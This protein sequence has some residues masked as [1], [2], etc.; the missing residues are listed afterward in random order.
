YDIE[1][2]Q[3]L[4]ERIPVSIAE[5]RRLHTAVLVRI[6]IQQAALEAELRDAPL[7]LG[8]RVV[9]RRAGDLRKARHADEL[10]RHQLAASVDQI[11]RDL[12]PVVHDGRG[13]LR[14]H[15]LKRPR[16]D[17]LHVDPARAHVIEMAGRRHLLRVPR[18]EN[19]LVVELE[20]AATVRASMRDEARLVSPVRLG[21][22]DVGVAIDDHSAPTMW[23]W[24][25]LLSWQKYSMMSS[26]GV[27]IFV[28]DAVHG[29]VY[30]RGSSIVTS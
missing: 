6:G 16:R 23:Y 2:A 10:V 13:P 29:R 3:L 8:K 14:V 7:E 30:V 19:V 24:S 25:R 17:E 22:R 28:H 18:G 4:V 15:H 27:H 11:V 1:L 9:D 20:A 21:T 5:R 12:G 26:S